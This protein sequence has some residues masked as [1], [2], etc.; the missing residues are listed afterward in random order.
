LRLD[1]LTVESMRAALGQ[2]EPSFACKELEV[3]QVRGEP[4][5]MS[6]RAPS[7]DDVKHLTY[8]AFAPRSALPRLDRRYVAVRGGGDAFATFDRHHIETLAREVA[9]QA[10]IVDAVWL[11]A[12]DG[13][14]YDPRRSRPLPVLRVRYDD[15]DQTWLYLD[16]ERG[17]VVLRHVRVTRRLRWLYHGLHSF[18]FPWLYFR[19]PW[20]DVVVILSSAGGAV[21]SAAAVVPAWRRVRRRIRHL[22]AG[23]ASQHAE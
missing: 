5:W 19:R 18:D 3:V 7:M 12:Y 9:P 15:P 1:L 23:A 2:I 13:Y 11:T 6:R 17:A 4:Y 16:P 22:L 14:Y 20:W 10:A 8:G 21:L